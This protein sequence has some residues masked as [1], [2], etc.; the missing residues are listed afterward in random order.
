MWC[1]A[2]T[3]E[4]PYCIASKYKIK[5]DKNLFGQYGKH[6]THQLLTVQH[7]HT[8]EHF[9]PLINHN[10]WHLQGIFNLRALNCSATIINSQSAPWN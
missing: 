9:L 8:E 5:L 10:S 1:L 4:S 3:I 6:L 7:N 2:N